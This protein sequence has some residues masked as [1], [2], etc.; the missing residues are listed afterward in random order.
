MQLTN[1]QRETCEDLLQETLLRA[2]RH[3]GHLAP[4]TESVR[5]WLYTVARRVAIDHYRAARARPALAIIADID[6]VPSPDDRIEQLLTTEAVR[7]A[8]RTL[9]PQHREVLYQIFYGGQTLEEAAITLGIPT[10]TAKSR[11]HYA[12]RAL[13]ARLATAIR[14]LDA[15][16]GRP[17][18]VVAA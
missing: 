12:Q 1:G 2:W 3:L 14:Q 18:A 4:D 7:R 13:R 17:R 8:L 11:A 5:P 6:T 16:Q 15:G 9:S 10:G